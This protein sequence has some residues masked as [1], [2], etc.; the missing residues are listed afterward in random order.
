MVLW[1]VNKMKLSFLII[2][3]LVISVIGT[4]ALVAPVDAVKYHGSALF[5]NDNGNGDDGD[6][7]P[8]VPGSNHTKPHIP[9]PWVQDQ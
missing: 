8:W 1:E 7:L 2:F 6:S 3:L 9:G 5:V 4:A